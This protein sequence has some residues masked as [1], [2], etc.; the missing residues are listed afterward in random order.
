MT[1]YDDDNEESFPVVDA[2]NIKNEEEEEEEEYKIYI[3]RVPTKFT[4]DIVKRILIDKLGSSDDDDDDRNNDGNIMIVEKVELIYPHDDDDDEDDDKNNSGEAR[5]KDRQQQR[6]EGEEHRGFGFVTFVTEKYRD[7]AIKLQ[8]IRGGTKRT[9]KKKHTMYLRPYVAKTY[10]DDDDDDDNNDG[11]DNSNNDKEGNDSTNNEQPTAGRRDVCYLWNLHRCPYGEECKFK[12]VGEGSCQ[13]IQNKKELEDLLSP[14]EQNKLQRKRKGKCF[15]YK[16]KGKCDKGDDCPFSHDF[17]VASNILIENTTANNKKQKRSNDNDKNESEGKYN[18]TNNITNNNKVKLSNSQK[19]CINWKT[20]GKCRKGDRCE[21]KHDLELQR[22]AL[23]KKAKKK[24]QRDGDDGD[25]DNDNK[26]I[27]RKEKQPLCVRVF[28]LNYDT[29]ENDIKEFIQKTNDGHQIKSI[30]FPKWEDS[31]RSKGYCG[32]YFAS[33]K[34]AQ[35]CVTK[36]DN[37]EL[38][39]RWLR[40]Q[41]GKSMTVDQW[42]SLHTKQYS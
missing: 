14:E 35:D 2:K 40:V 6:E 11:K 12:H 34:A 23:D 20:K 25:D 7:D 15:I 42:D 17:M 41:T 22:K 4:E 5:K 28:G 3:G 24:R 30:L 18:E 16:K 26:R 38:H 39:G 9:S 27:K 10:D 19:D 1:D 36:C 8:T 21:Y 29:T 33:P 31:Q 13:V 37:A 32:I